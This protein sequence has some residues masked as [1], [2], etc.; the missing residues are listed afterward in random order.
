MA[1][2]IYYCKPQYERAYRWGVAGCVT[3]HN[4]VPTAA[5]VLESHVL[6][7][8]VETSSPDEAWMRMQAEIWSP[9]GEGAPLISKLGLDHTSMSVGDV[10]EID[11]I[12]Y[13]V[14]ATGFA[15]L[16]KE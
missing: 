13:M 7:R 10:V 11:G 12:F 16:A 15:A 3:D 2:N 5:T 4:P 6:V 8:T 14:E 9:N 1:A